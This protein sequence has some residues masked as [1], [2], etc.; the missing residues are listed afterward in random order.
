MTTIINIFFSTRLSITFVTYRL[1][2]HS[3]MIHF[4]Q[5]HTH[6]TIRVTYSLI[7]HFGIQPRNVG[8]RMCFV[9]A[10]EN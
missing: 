8:S 10:H 3:T 2:D 7:F 5:I 4:I 9:S 6:T 1:L